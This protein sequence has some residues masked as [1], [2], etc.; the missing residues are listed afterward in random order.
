MSDRVFNFSAGPGVLPEPVLRQA[1]QDLWN[2]HGSGI[3]ILE[4]SHRGK[5]FDRV[6]AEAEAD[7]RE[8]GSIPDDYAVLFLPGGASSQFYMIPMNFCAADKSDTVDYFDTGE[9]SHKAIAE[10]KLFANVNVCGSSKATNYDHVPKGAE[11]KLSA[12]PKY[13]YI[14]SNSTVFGN[15]FKQL[16]AVPAGVPLISDS[17]SDIYSEPIDVRKYHFIYAGAQKNLGPA[18]T[19]L[20]IARKDYLETGRADLPTMLQYRTHVKNQSRYNTPPTFG[21]YLV[22]QTFKWIKS[23]GGL[24]AMAERNRA[25]AA[26]LYDHLDSQSFFT[27]LAKKED[28]SPMNVVFKCP[29]PELDDL[30]VKQAEKHGLDGLKGHRSIGGMRASIYNAFPIEGVRA[31]VE[32]MKTFER[33]HRGASKPAMAGAR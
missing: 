33:E 28:R 24:K 30:F 10:A 16:P 7:C 32:F 19:V 5:V 14:E 13:V 9:W 17:S 4:H 20:V 2:I 6:L 12:R 22:G 11:V 1:Q 8:V 29:T 21:I 31:L 26:A 18:S 3:G 27:P 23:I 25:K 15:Q